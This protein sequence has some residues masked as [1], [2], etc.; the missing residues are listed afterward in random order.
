M[1]KKIKINSNIDFRHIRIRKKI[2]GSEDKPRLS[3]F[4][5]LKHLE[6]QLVN[7]FEGKTLL[8]LS[9]RDKNFKTNLKER[10]NVKAA[11]E[12]GQVFATKAKEKGYGSV[13]FDRGGRLYHG[14]IKAFADSAR[15]AGLLF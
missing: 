10:G 2:R 7:D 8:S 11:V 14:R 3:V 15:K 1:R 4:R 6:A 5:S 12:L 13:V 9:T